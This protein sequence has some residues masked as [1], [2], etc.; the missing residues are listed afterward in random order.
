VQNNNA[1][2]KATKKPTTKSGGKT[3]TEKATKTKKASKAPK[4]KQT[5][6]KGAREWGEN[7]SDVA[8]RHKARMKTERQRR[9][10]KLV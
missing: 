5:R 2:A 1:P 3:T 8:E 10:E 4:G 7:I 6:S 9:A